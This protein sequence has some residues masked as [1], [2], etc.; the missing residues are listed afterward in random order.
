MA[1]SM[2][3]VQ[4]K[5][6]CFNAHALRCSVTCRVRLHRRGIPARELA[7]Q[8]G[9]KRYAEVIRDMNRRRYGLFVGKVVNAANW[10]RGKA[11]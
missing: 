8:Q 9:L 7:S 6:P 3:G 10:L 4:T 1:W 11:A 5:F 2:I